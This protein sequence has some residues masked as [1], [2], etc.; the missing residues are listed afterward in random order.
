MWIV[1][2]GVF[3]LTPGEVSN[4]SVAIKESCAYSHGDGDEGRS[5]E[6]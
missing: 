3:C 5:V 1:E 2:L 6:G 4:L